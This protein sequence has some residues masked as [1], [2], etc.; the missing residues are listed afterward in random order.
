[1]GEQ[2]GAVL[3]LF[4]DPLRLIDSIRYGETRCY[5][6]EKGKIERV[7]V[8]RN[9]RLSDR[10]HEKKKKKWYVSEDAKQKHNLRKRTE[11]RCTVGHEPIMG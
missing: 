4:S 11:A 8:N 1:M 5:V 2:P 6:Y 3:L 7:S 9:T 10:S